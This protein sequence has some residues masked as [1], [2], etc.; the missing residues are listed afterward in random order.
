MCA[1][2]AQA[3]ADAGIAV[4]KDH[5]AQ[6]GHVDQ[7]RCGILIGSAMGGMATFAQGVEDLT[8]RVSLPTVLL[9][10]PAVYKQLWCLSYMCLPSVLFFKS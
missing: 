4:E 10:T 3:L 5:I 8:L 7:Q 6:E 2:V 9:P 1:S